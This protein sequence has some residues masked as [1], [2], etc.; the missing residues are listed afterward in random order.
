MTPERVE[1]EPLELDWLQ[2]HNEM[3]RA[4]GVETTK[5][6]LFRKIKEN[7]FVPIGCLATTMALCYGLVSFKR[8]DT[9]MSQYMMRSRVAA[10]GFTVVALVAGLGLTAMKNP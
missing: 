7:P 8:G 10:Q 4:A 6:K 3:N 9:K 5:E 2:L 1:E